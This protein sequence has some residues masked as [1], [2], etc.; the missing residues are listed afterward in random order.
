MSD[1]PRNAIR[2]LETFET[3]FEIGNTHGCVIPLYQLSLTCRKALDQN[4]VK[5]ALLLLDRFATI[6]IVCFYLNVMVKFVALD[7]RF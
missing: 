7:I 1:Q 4:D 3:F 5:K 2:P 6:S